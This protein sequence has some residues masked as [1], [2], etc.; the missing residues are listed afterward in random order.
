LTLGGYDASKFDENGITWSFNEEDV[1]DLTVQVSSISVTNSSITSSLLSSP[2]SMFIDSTVPY[3]WLPLDAC[4]QFE[5]AFNLTWDNNTQLYLLD[6]KKHTALLSQ[7][8]SVVFTLQNGGSSVNITLPYAA[9]DLTASYPLVANPTR[10]FP[11]KR[12]KN[13][14]QYTL[15]RT[16]LQEA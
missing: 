5:K 9:F 3:I 11:L 16:F 15:G 1:R 13:K 8:S 6:D 2:V 10:Y 7:N 14:N 4:K 12:A